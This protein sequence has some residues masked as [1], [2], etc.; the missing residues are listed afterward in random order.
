MQEYRKQVREIPANPFLQNQSR[1]KR[2]RVAAYCRVSTEQEQQESSFEN[3]VAYYT[4]L[5]QSNPDWEFA[6]IFADWGIS[7]TKDTI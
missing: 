2:L 3:Q 1:G 7:G 6:G 4:N 5:I